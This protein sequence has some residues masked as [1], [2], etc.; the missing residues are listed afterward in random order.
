MLKCRFPENKVV[1]LDQLIRQVV[2]FLRLLLVS[3]R[4]IK[5][6][7]LVLGLFLVAALVVFHVT[8]ELSQCVIDLN[9]SGVF[10]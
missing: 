9:E 4:W 5:L 6:V 3:L 10:L 1:V 8:V 7:L 2:F